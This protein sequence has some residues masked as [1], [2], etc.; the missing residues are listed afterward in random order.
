M[1]RSKV[2]RC[3]ALSGAL[4]LAMYPLVDAHAQQTQP[5]GQATPADQAQKD[6]SEKDKN[7]LD[8]VVVTGS[9]IK[10][11]QAEGPAPVTVLTG[12]QLKKEG[13]STVYEAVRSLT[14]A[15]GNVQNDYDWG[16]SAV[17]VKP[18]NLR[19]LGPGRSLLLI[20]GRRV[21]DYPLPYG[22]KG[23]VANFNNIPTGIV[24][25][26]EVLTGSASAIYGSDAMGGVVNVILK[27]SAQGQTLRAK[28]GEATRG[29]FR[30]LDL[31]ASGGLSG[32]KWNLT[33]DLQHFYRGQLLAKDRPFMDSEDDVPYQDW[34]PGQRHFG[35]GA[36]TPSAGLYLRDR[37]APANPTGRTYIA[38]PAG[39]CDQYG[40]LYYLAS[41]LAYDR[42]TGTASNGGQY[43]AQRVFQNWSLK[44]GSK[45]DS[46]YLYGTYEVNDKLEAWASV[47][48][49]KT[50]GQFNTFLD[51]FGSPV[52]WD[53][54]ANNGAGGDRSFLKYQSPGE[55]GGEK[56]VLT[57]S[58]ETSIDLSAGLRGRIADRYDWE[59][60]VGRAVYSDHESFPTLNQGLMQD[61]YMGP[62][63]GTAANGN[64]I[65]QPDYNKL[66]NP[67]P[68]SDTAP[69]SKRGDN[70]AISFLNQAQVTMSGDLFKGWA[71]PIGFA[72]TLEYGKQGYH[73]TP[74][75]KTLSNDPDGWYTPFGNIQ[76]GGGTRSHYGAA[77][78]FKVPL[79]KM[80]TADL[81]TRYD[82]YQAT[83]NAGKLTY[84]M[85]LEFRPT[86]TLLFRGTYGTSFRA[87]DMNFIYRQPSTG[88][89]SM[90]DLNWC[91]LDGWPNRQCIFDTYKASNIVISR[92][93]SPDLRYETGTSLSYGFVWDAFKNFSVSVDLWD[94][95]I[96]NLIDDISEDQL[97][98]DDAYCKYHWTP[99]G[100]TRA[101]P[102]SATYCADVAKRIIRAPVV[103]GGSLAGNITQINVQP[104]NRAD[105]HV[106]GLDI[107]LNYAL[108]KTRIGTFRL[109]AALTN[110]ITYETR[111][112]PTDQ[113]ENSRA[114]QTTYKFT[115]N[116]NWN[117][118]RWNATLAMYQKAGGRDNRYG[119]CMPFADGYIPSS[120]TYCQD[121]SSPA[122]PT[123]GQWTATHKEHRPARRY[124]N[125]SL[126]Y[127]FNDNLKINFYG[128]NLLN[129]IYQDK[130]CGDFAYC[131]DDP[132][133]RELSAEI[134]YHF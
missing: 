2:F 18:L 6:K 102:P 103:P 65:Y 26:I 31:E 23:N 9:R 54:R 67:V 40:S 4:L 45:N 92:S 55:L 59:A 39:A 114:Y 5:D 119:G 109:G 106:R 87:P 93:G 14:E 130:W 83:Q 56:N 48:V 53:P 97:L 98:L 95:K 86:S 107:H 75:P 60:S 78:E 15:V 21:A 113:L 110:Q 12:E 29:G 37:D 125:G 8:A 36:L 127:Q 96:K 7:Q 16:Q 43:C 10:R 118:Q 24:D 132:V 121:L 33:Y 25:R 68:A 99:D 47:G 52:Y 124:F 120:G 88:L 32:K 22:G 101:S 123:Y 126:G 63:L 42:N 90:T 44:T 122:S 19:N 112:F 69:F 66:W 46:G 3:T 111:Q 34:G 58:R 64:P 49:W 27:K 91:Y 62:Q 85:G 108:P 79:L 80:L 71:G 89:K 81:A 94:I 129:K 13:F 35:V 11:S 131:V 74:D 77:L 105:T 128:A 73:L 72:S 116:V 134:V 38:P 76:Q 28:W 51:G 50:S 70:K 100:S 41:R 133:G 82:K 104:I 115:G 1:T 61:Y 17:N 30:N 117:Y 57:I 20:N 84:Q